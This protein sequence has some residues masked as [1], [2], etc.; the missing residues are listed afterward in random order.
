[1]AS[2]GIASVRAKGRDLISSICGLYRDGAMLQPRWESRRAENLHDLLGPGG[3]G[4][5][6]ILRLAAQQ[7]VPDTAAHQ[8]GA[9]TPSLDG[10]KDALRLFSAH[11]LSSDAGIGCCTSL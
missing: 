1:M 6:P 7:Q 4:N 3:G 11:N 9:I 5:V 10:F 2:I 8:I